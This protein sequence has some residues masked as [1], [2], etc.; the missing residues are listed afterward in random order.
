MT[1]GIESLQWAFLKTSKLQSDLRLDVHD[2]TKIR[3]SNMFISLVLHRVNRASIPGITHANR[4]IRPLGSLWGIVH[5]SSLCP[6]DHSC[7]QKDPS[8]FEA[9][10]RSIFPCY[11]GPEFLC[12]YVVSFTVLVDEYTGLEVLY[13]LFEVPNFQVLEFI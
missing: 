13:P 5:H 6:R 7:N 8:F 12:T 4:T 3:G 2:C 1:V 11:S 10:I 9:T